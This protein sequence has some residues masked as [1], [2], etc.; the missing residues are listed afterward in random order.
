MKKSEFGTSFATF[1]KQFDKN[2]DDPAIQ[3][4]LRNFAEQNADNP[5]DVPLYFEHVYQQQRMDN[6]V[7]DALETFL[8]FDEE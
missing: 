3:Q 7:K 4:Q 5:D 6:L 8:T 1:K 2:F